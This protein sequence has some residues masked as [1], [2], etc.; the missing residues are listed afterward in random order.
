M[1]LED[2]SPIETVELVSHLVQ[3]VEHESVR[4]Q[5][6]HGTCTDENLLLPLAD[7]V[8]IEK[9]DREEREEE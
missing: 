2:L 9:R 6:P 5:L 1:H 7:G 3:I 8:S 4:E